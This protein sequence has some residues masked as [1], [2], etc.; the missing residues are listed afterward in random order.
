MRLVVRA[1]RASFRPGGCRGHR[2]DYHA[3]VEVEGRVLVDEARSFPDG[4]HVLDETVEIEDEGGGLTVVARVRDGDVW[5]DEARRIHRPPYPRRLIIQRGSWVIE[6]RLSAPTTVRRPPRRARVA[7]SS[8]G[9][10][11]ATRILAPPAALRVEIDPVIPVPDRPDL[12]RPQW[13]HATEP[14][15]VRADLLGDRTLQPRVN[16]SVIARTADPSWVATIS[17]TKIWAPGWDEA[18]LSSRIE[19][20][21]RSISGGASLRFLGAPRGLFVRVLGEGGDGEVAI[22]ALLRGEVVASHVALVRRPVTI[23]VRFTFYRPPADRSSLSVPSPLP[24]DFPTY[25]GEPEIHDPYAPGRAANLITDANTMLASLALRLVSH[26]DPEPTPEA[27][28]QGI[29][30]HPGEPGVFV[31]NDCPFE[32][33]Q[34]RR[35][36]LGALVVRNAPPWVLHVVAF[37]VLPGNDI[38]VTPLPC[39][40]ATET[41]EDH[42]DP[43]SSWVAP[44][45]VP[46]DEPARERSILPVHRH[47]YPEMLSHVTSTADHV[48]LALSGFGVFGG[49]TLAHEL[50]HALGLRHRHPDADGLPSLGETNLMAPGSSMGD[51]DRLQARVAW[52]SSIVRHHHRLVWGDDPP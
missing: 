6:L 30:W 20:R 9:Y 18:D 52:Q 45:G 51:L 27:A 22:D 2:G 49:G 11:Y 39:L 25:G 38:G 5:R 44:S 34:P 13:T 26:P 37:C 35:D 42:L 48:G 4:D 16:P 28:A 33:I 50:G 21:A 12:R 10:E 41:V 31:R 1:V 19:W 3:H 14:N 47:P 8:P 7:R 15:I 32:L 29:A 40:A 23:P 43:S 24:P 36:E 17:Y 46:P